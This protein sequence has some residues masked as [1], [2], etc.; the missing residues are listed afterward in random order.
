[1]RI[2][3]LSYGFTDF[4]SFFTTYAS[5]LDISQALLASLF[6]RAPILQHVQQRV[7]CRE[8]FGNCDGLVFGDAGYA[9]QEGDVR[10]AEGV[11]EALKLCF[12]PWAET[13][14]AVHRELLPER[15]VDNREVH[16]FEKVN[17]FHRCVHLKV[18]KFVLQCQ[19]NLELLQVLSRR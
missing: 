7:K 11:G 12:F 15:L 18:V 14:A 19:G 2:D 8:L 1:V 9:H 10:Q 4:L 13:L 17:H 5:D 16:L 6:R 3:L